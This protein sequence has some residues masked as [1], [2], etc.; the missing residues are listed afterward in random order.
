MPRYTL[1]KGEFHI[2]YRERPRGGP[3]PDGDTV[4]FKPDS[5]RLIEDLPWQGRPADI[6]SKG[7]IPIRLEGID[8]LETH[9]KGT[10]QQL[11]LADAARDWLLARLGFTGVTFWDDLPNNVRT[12][13]NSPLRG[14]I[15]A[16]GLDSNGRVLAFVYAG[17]SD[18]PN[19]TAVYLELDWMLE[20]LNTALIRSSLVYATFYTS[21]PADLLG[22]L[23]GVAATARL[24]ETKIWAAESL[25]T[26]VD[27]EVST[28]SALE[29]LVIW[30]KLFRRLVDYLAG[31]N[32]GLAGFDD[33]LRVD[34]VHRDDRVLLPDG[35]LGNIHDLIS[36]TP[37]NKIRL[38]FNP[39]DVVFLPDGA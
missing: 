1:I 33:W 20:S 22:P 15:L 4:S 19:G 39:E 34:S 31:G 9:F 23:R 8:A 7:I 5:P 28:T 12:V 36:I 24:S 30:P 17:E 3:Q 27:L 16:N 32:V 13:N 2:F 29:G 25:N 18:T 21:L 37:G 11:D 6:N 38:I 35:E 14:Y 10:H 26:R